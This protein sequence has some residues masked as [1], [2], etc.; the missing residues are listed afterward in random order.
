MSVLSL[1]ATR[2]E[3]P[4]TDGLIDAGVSR[5]VAA[6]RDPNPL[7]EGGGF[8]L[9]QG[10]GIEVES[11]VLEDQARWL[12]RGFVSRM[13]RQKPWVRLKSAA[14]LDGR[15]AAYDGE[16]KWITSDQ[17]RQSVQELRASCSVSYTHLTLPTILLV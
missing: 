2:A 13:V 11:G 16:S 17:A 3:H 4:C 8:E 15:T 7:V 12:N 14:T 6:M 1:A 5:V 9:L 10:A